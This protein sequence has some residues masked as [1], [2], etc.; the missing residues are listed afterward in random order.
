MII[1]M[2]WSPS[3]DKHKGLWDTAKELLILLRELEGK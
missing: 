2:G 1:Q 3:R